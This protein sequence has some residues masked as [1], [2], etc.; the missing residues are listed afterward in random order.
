M[1]EIQ[2]EEVSIETQPEVVAEETNEV[3]A[4]T[5]PAAPKRRGR[6]PG[7]RNKPKAVVIP[8]TKPK[9]K[10]PKARPQ[11]PE[12]SEEEAPPPP[13]RRRAP[14]PISEASQDSVSPDP[15]DTRAIAAE[16]LN[17]LSNRHQDRSQA[18]RE[19]YA[20]WFA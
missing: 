15:P 4:T 18:R 5:P 17:I 2:I 3:E 6:P 10:K 7:A 1:A 11:T 20:S 19:K 16:V 14:R 12:E 9:A 8:E 13:R